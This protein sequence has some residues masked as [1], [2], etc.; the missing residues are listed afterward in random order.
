[1]ARGIFLHRPDSKYADFPEERYQ[2]PKQYLGRAAQFV[3][4]WIIYYEPVKAGGKGYY[5]IAKV[6][7]IVPDPSVNDMYLA[8]IEARSYQTFWRPVPFNNKDGLVEK[9]LLNEAGKVSGRAQAAVRPVSIDD[10][11]RILE[12]GMPDD[13]LL[14]RVGH[15]GPEP[16][17]NRLFEEASPFVFDQQRDRISYMNN[18][19]VRDRIFRK[20]VLDAY[21]CRCAITGLKFINGG[22]RAEVEAAH[23]KPVE[24]NGPD[25]VR[26]G[27]A[28]C[29]TAHWMFDRGMISLS[30]NMDVMV[31][32]HVNDTEGIWGL[33]NQSRKALV[34]ASPANRPHERYLEWHRTQCFKH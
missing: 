3:G 22:G 6:E 20:H 10:F 34:P 14:P 30:E 28:L 11:N 1:M 8:L 7:K 19:I 5:A 27:L 31:S 13:D 12:Q 25:D 16:A 33:I 4:D 29:G 15:F 24:M 32:R 26:N 23:I 21:D 17:H 9:G 18:R 2:F